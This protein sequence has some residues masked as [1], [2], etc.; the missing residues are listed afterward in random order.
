MW[1]IQESRRQWKREGSDYSY[2]ELEKL[3]VA[4]NPFQCFIDPDAPDFVAPGDMPGRIKEFCRRT[5][6]YV[7]Q[8]VG[9]TVRCI[10]ESLALKYRHV[11]NGLKD[12]T[13][14]DYNHIN[15]VGG[16]TKDGL[17]CAM[18]AASCGVPVYAGPIEAT[19]LGNIAVQLMS[20]GEIKDIAEARRVIAA[21]EN[22][23]TFDPADTA[24][25]DEAYET[26]VKY[27]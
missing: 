9:E 25:W 17:L 18:T 22:L 10:Y 14:K 6:Q 23:K 3:A 20:L 2:A 4:S 21:G 16:G 8:T 5:G 7:P 12:C 11:F 26:Y 1:L 27:L 24:A 15:V 19:V 13:G